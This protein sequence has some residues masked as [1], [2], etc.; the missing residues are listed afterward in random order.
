MLDVV[1]MA[2]KK[3]DLLVLPILFPR[4]PGDMLGI[5]VVDYLTA[6]APWCNVTVLDLR[7][8]GPARG[9]TEER[10]GEARVLRCALS[11]ER[12]P[13][14]LE[15]LLY[16]RWLRRGVALA[17]SLGPFD[18]IHAHGSALTGNLGLA[19][20]ASTGTPVVVTEHSSP[21]PR[22]RKRPVAR[23]LARR[24]ID[25]ADLALFVSDGLRREYAE[26]GMRPRRSA[27]TY[28]PV[29]TALFDISR[30]PPPAE[31][32]EILFVGRLERFKGAGRAVDAFRAIAEAN[33]D[34]RFTVIG[35]GPEMP[36]LRSRLA[37][38]PLLAARVA[39][40]G[41]L[42][43]QDIARAMQRSAFLVLP[44]ERET[45]GLVVAEAMACGLPVIVGDST[46]AT[47]FVGPGD[48]IAVP[49]RDV[50]ALATAM[51]R[52]IATLGRY[53]PQ[54]IRA[55]IVSRFGFASFGERMRDLYAS[56][57]RPG[58]VS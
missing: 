19:I 42:G 29:D 48:G 35:D 5:F 16:L 46:G 13:A 50:G 58:T 49:A 12:P 31:R 7:I 39:L 8:A 43:K 56:V 28:N 17:R 33:P 57:A 37:A 53:D 47:E 3:L 21:W 54:G 1:P 9:P 25:G 38:D 14:V 32:R 52:L 34:W 20:G 24:A 15:P 11:R 26:C 18:V 55:G 22:L 27:V 23:W 6:V 44:S 4:G 30:G 2:D 41:Q 45:F 10:M 36:E 51:Q 40:A